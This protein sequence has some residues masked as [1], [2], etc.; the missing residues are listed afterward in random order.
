VAAIRGIG[1]RMRS[2]RRRT[3]LLFQNDLLLL[4]RC[5]CF[6]RA[7]F[8]FPFHGGPLF[9][10]GFSLGT[11]RVLRKRSV[12]R[13]RRRASGHARPIDDEYRKDEE[14]SSDRAVQLISY[15]RIH[16]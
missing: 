8:R 16:L 9:L 11:L 4:R 10:P 2:W 13:R 5:F 1:H 14:N 6:R 7:R 12:Y 3:G 15:S